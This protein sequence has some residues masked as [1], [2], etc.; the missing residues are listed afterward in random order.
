MNTVYLEKRDPARNMM[1]FYSIRIT[2]TLF[3][4][5][6]LIR[7]WG[8]IGSKG[9]VLENW[10]DS[11]DDAERAGVKLRKAKERRGYLRSE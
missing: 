2:P 9:S 1:R 4:E 5:W 8:R 3:G 11:Q 7:Q 10:F 6:A